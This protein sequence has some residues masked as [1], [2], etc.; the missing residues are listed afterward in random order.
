[1]IKSLC[2]WSFFSEYDFYDRFEKAKEAGFSHVE[3]SDWD[4]KDIG[5]IKSMLDQYELTLTG[6]SGDKDLSIIDIE[7]TE[8]YIEYVEK[9]IE[10]AHYLGCDNLIIHSNGLS[11]NGVVLNDYAEKSYGEKMAVMAGTLVRL[12]PIAEDAGVTLNLEA[13]NVEVDHPGCFLSSTRDAVAA[14]TPAMS[15]N[16]KITYD[17]YHMQLSE[18]K[19]INTLNECIEHIGYIHIADVPGRAEPGTGEINFDMIWKTLRKLN[20]KGTIGFE[21]I[22][23]ASNEVEIAS[24]LLTLF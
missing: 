7:H 15:N 5:K 8:K 18:G 20:Y 9:S 6:F 14:V 23:S 17:I 24:N 2:L 4:G 10:T 16:V 1:M 21:L 13:L 19:L 22:P 11:E 12:A 3:F